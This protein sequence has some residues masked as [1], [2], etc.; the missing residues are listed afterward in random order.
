MEKPKHIEIERKFLVKGDFIPY[1]SKSYEI[2][3]GYML[4][5][6]EK[7]VRVR[8]KGDKGYLTIK[9]KTNENGFSRFEWEKEIS[10]TDAELLLALCDENTI[11]KTRYE[12]LFEGKVFEI[13]RFY[14]VNEGLL[15]AELELESEDEPFATPDWLGQEVTHDYRYYNSYLSKN[16]FTRW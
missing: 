15:L 16:P 10:T 12:V 13:D 8:V 11:S 4:A 6:P 1:V 7:T 5:S 9:G 14:G 3:Q 2:K